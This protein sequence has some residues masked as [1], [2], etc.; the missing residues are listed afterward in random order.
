MPRC[1][2]DVAQILNVLV[3]RITEIGFVFY[4]PNLASDVPCQSGDPRKLASFFTGC[5]HSA[6][7]DQLKEEPEGKEFQAKG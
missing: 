3:T 6:V 4:S 7:S 5:Q 1:E 2:L